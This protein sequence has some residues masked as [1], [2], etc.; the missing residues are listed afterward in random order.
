MNN[1]LTQG[2]GASAD[3]I[4]FHGYVHTRT[5]CPEPERIVDLLSG[6]RSVL[7]ANGQAGKPLFNTEGGWGRTDFDGFND[8]E[9][10]AAF[11]AIQQFEHA[12]RFTEAIHDRH[13]IDVVR[14]VTKAG[15]ESGI[16]A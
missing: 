10:Q 12:N 1:F 2:G 5:C 8:P 16:K 14:A 11:R 3:I 7:A 9:Q 4:A 13:A 15:V 6:L